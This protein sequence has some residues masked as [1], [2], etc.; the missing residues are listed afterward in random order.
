MWPR[1]HHQELLLDLGERK[2]WTERDLEHAVEQA[3]AWFVREQLL[4]SF[5]TTGEAEQPDL[6]VLRELGNRL[7]VDEPRNG[8]ARWL[9]GLGPVVGSSP[10]TLANSLNNGLRP[11]RSDHRWLA[12]AAR[13]AATPEQVDL[14]A[15]LYHRRTPDSVASALSSMT[16]DHVFDAGDALL[17]FSLVALWQR[18]RPTDRVRGNKGQVRRRRDT[19]KPVSA[20]KGELASLGQFSRL[21]T[22]AELL[23]D[24]SPLRLL[25][26]EAALTE[27]HLAPHRSR[28]ARKE[29]R[30]TGEAWLSAVSDA[31]EKG[32]VAKSERRAFAFRIERMRAWRDSRSMV[33]PDPTSELPYVRASLA[34]ERAR[35]GARP[36]ESFRTSGE[37]IFMVLPLLRSR[38]FEIQ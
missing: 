3:S 5:L 15:W 21:L 24:G 1:R 25:A 13:V 28:R 23:N 33:V 7:A 2:G 11:D 18:R 8:V 36:L 10:K 9:T 6:D 38:G 14:N 4:P 22:L 34:L 35:A 17:V 12:V 16:Q 29:S 31:N 26:M 20:L 30:T 32:N 37:G 19:P 27:A